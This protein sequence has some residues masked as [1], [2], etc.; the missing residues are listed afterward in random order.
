MLRV[1]V[2]DDSPSAAMLT[3]AMLKHAGHACRVAH[4]AD[5]GIELV[6]QERPDLVLMDIQMPGMDG[7]TA[8]RLLKLDAA[9]R[10][11]PVIALTAMA[12]RGDAD[13]IFQAG[14]IGYIPMPVHYGTFIQSI[15]AVTASR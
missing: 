9:L 4:M 13:M 5:Q 1:V 6:R 15:E 14:C 12:M 8:T 10:H 7:L 11:I 3:E 2:I